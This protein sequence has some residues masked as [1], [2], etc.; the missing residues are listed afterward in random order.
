MVDEGSGP[1]YADCFVTLPKSGVTLLR[2]AHNGGKG[3]ALRVGLRYARQHFPGQV[4][5]TA[6]ADGQHLVKDNLALGQR[7]QRTGRFCLRVRNFTGVEVTRGT[8]PGVAGGGKSGAAPAS[9][10]GA[11][12]VVDSHG[13]PCTIPWRSRFGNRMT[14]T[15]FRWATGVAVSDTQTGLRAFPP[16]LLGEALAVPGRR[17]E[18]ELRVLLRAATQAWPLEQ[19][20]ITTVYEESN[21][22][23]HFQPLRDSWRIYRPLLRQLG[24]RL[25]TLGRGSSARRQARQLPPATPTLVARPASLVRPQVLGLQ[26]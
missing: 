15:L 9:A 4:V 12:A 20:P 11:P 23:S 25:S 6:D 24:W 17:Y 22:S 16:D 8:R 19:V 10:G 26:P 14:I 18:W 1:D 3:H 2:L 13:Q 21:P 7:A 5:V